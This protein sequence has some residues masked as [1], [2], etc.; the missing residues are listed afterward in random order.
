MLNTRKMIRDSG[1]LQSAQ[2]IFSVPLSDVPRM[3]EMGS[4]VC[5]FPIS[6]RELASP[7][8]MLWTWALTLLTHS[9]MACVPSF[10]PIHWNSEMGVSQHSTPSKLRA[11]SR[12]KP[13]CMFPEAESAEKEQH[14]IYAG[15]D[16]W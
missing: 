15:F 10:K 2:A 7:L 11:R 3:T 16:Y 13:V 12:T 4:M 8:R 9:L 1:G 14:G 6:S 5:S